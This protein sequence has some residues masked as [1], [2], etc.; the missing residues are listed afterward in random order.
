MSGFVPYQDIDIKFSGLRPGEKLYEELLMDEEGLQDTENKLI[1]IG[2]PIKLDEEKFLKALDNL[3]MACL[4]E[5]NPA[6]VRKLV[7]DIVPTYKPKNPVDKASTKDK[8]DKEEE[9]TEEKDNGKTAEKDKE[10]TVEKDEKALDKA[11]EKATE[12]AEEK[13]ADKAADKAEEK[14]PEKTAEKS[15]EKSTEKAAEKTE[16]KPA[17]KEPEKE[18]TADT[19]NNKQ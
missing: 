15:E 10:K 9:K 16:D 13:T 5:P 14:D 3:Y 8:K 12:K 17:E 6:T 11:A 1:H 7:G 4:D 18:K 2:K 19:D